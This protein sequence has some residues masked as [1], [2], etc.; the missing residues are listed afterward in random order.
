MLCILC[1]LLY[2][3]YNLGGNRDVY[4]KVKIQNIVFDIPQRYKAVKL[5]GQGA[6]GQVVSAVEIRSGMTLIY[7]YIYVDL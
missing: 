6:Y 5:I 4:N 3:V 1:F 2:F 7:L